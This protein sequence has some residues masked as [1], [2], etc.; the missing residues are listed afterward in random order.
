MMI[1]DNEEIPM[2]DGIILDGE[3]ILDG[4]SHQISFDL[5]DNIS[6]DDYIEFLRMMKDKF[7]FEDVY[8]YRMIFLKK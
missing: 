5:N 1:T 4:K 7:E 3:S 8:T 2:P 6:L